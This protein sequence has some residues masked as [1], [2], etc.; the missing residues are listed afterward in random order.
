MQ[1]RGQGRP[2]TCSRLGKKLP[3]FQQQRQRQSVGQACDNNEHDVRPELSSETAKQ[4]R[5]KFEDGLWKDMEQDKIS[6]RKS[7][8]CFHI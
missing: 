6:S 2:R 8:A 1:L 4:R 3:Q 7:L 5:P